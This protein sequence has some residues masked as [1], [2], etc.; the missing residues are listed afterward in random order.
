MNQTDKL[1]PKQK[2]ILILL[3]RFRFLSR[4]H[5]Q[6]HLNHKEY[7]R[8][9]AWLKNLTAKNYIH[10]I[11][12]KTYGQNFMPAIYF[13]KTK[14]AQTLRGEKEV[15][16]K[17]LT[18]IYREHLRSDNF[19]ENCLLQADIYLSLKSLCQK[20][21]ANFHFF[22]KTD[23]ASHYYLPK[24]MPDLYFTI[25]EG[26]VIKRYFLEIYSNKTPR[27]ALRHRVLRFFNNYASNVWEKTTCHPFPAVLLV[28]P[29]KYILSYLNKFIS[30]TMEEEDN[31]EIKFFL[32]TKGNI[33]KEG[34]GVKVWKTVS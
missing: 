15:N 16:E 27:Y 11:Y 3:Y 7:R 24:P 1:T 34:V 23:L 12:S 8:I 33:R 2:E 17:L 25:N 22:T 21:K 4:H 29:D 10:R 9:N 14:S 5:I 18:R 6:H 19:I 30:E 20:S 31:F 13:L 26:K 28:C 32:A